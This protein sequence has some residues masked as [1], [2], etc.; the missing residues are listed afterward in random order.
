MQT[1]WRLLAEQR[2]YARPASEEDG[3]AALEW[4]A[5]REGKTLGELVDELQAAAPAHVPERSLELG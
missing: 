3:K 2:V 1:A 4:I 5:A